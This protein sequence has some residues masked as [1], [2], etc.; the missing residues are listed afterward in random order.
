VGPPGDGGTTS[1]APTILLRASGFFTGEDRAINLGDAAQQIR[2]ISELR[3]CFPGHRIIALGNSIKDHPLS[4]SYVFS[5][6]LPSYLG[7]NPRSTR[8][9]LQLV[10]RIGWIVLNAISL[11]AFKR[12]PVRQRSARR[13]LRQIADSDFVFFSGAGAFNQ[14]YLYGVAGTWLLTALVARIL[15]VPVVLMGQQ[16]GPLKID[17]VNKV[18]FRLSLGRALLIGCRDAESIP[19]SLALGLRD[20]L[21]Q[22]TGDEGAYLEPAPWEEGKVVLG[23]HGQSP[24]F[25]A[26]QF[27]IDGNCPMDRF[28]DEFA[29]VIDRLALALGAPVLLIPMAYRGLN[30][31]RAALT[32]LKAQLSC[33]STFLE[34]EDPALLKACL[35][36]A[37]LALGVANHF[38]VFSSSVGVPVVGFYA[39]EYMRQK[40]Q[41]AARASGSVTALDITVTEVSRI[42]EIAL[43]KARDRSSC[44]HPPPFSATEP[45]GYWRW[46]SRLAGRGVIADCLDLQSI[47]DSR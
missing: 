21:V 28:L 44:E 23:K 46:L 31:D 37:A 8:D 7:S 27:R 33:R 38:V 2:A 3:R 39:T 35:A 41:G 40:L 12:A 18:L 11:R 16:I 34:C 47:H 5:T 43:Q 4:A 10:A 26:V 29:T 19:V 15:N 20:E 45:K 6:D 30:D 22:L 17:T 24:G 13:F 42:A 14:R 9:L 36:H 32:K 25:I 1:R